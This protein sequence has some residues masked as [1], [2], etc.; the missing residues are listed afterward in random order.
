M[1][2][3]S[4]ALETQYKEVMKVENRYLRKAWQIILRNFIKN[5]GEYQ[6]YLWEDYGTIFPNGAVHAEVIERVTTG[7]DFEDEVERSWRAQGIDYKGTPVKVGYEDI[8]LL[9][10]SKEVISLAIALKGKIHVEKYQGRVHLNENEKWNVARVCQELNNALGKT[11]KDNNGLVRTFSQTSVTTKAMAKKLIAFAKKLTQEDPAATKAD[12]KVME[13]IEAEFLKEY[14]ETASIIG[15]FNFYEGI[16]KRHHALWNPGDRLRNFKGSRWLC[17]QRTDG[18]HS[19]SSDY[20]IS[21]SP[22]EIRYEREN[23]KSQYG[24]FMQSRY[25]SDQSGDTQTYQYTGMVTDVVST[26][27]LVFELWRDQKDRSPES[28]SYIVLTLTSEA[29]P[30]V[31]IGF[32]MYYSVYSSRYVTKSVLFQHF[33]DSDI[34]FDL[35]PE[36]RK[37]PAEQLFPKL[38][39]DY[40]PDDDPKEFKEIPLLIRRFLARRDLNRLT[41]PSTRISSLEEGENSLAKWMDSR[42]G[43][44]AHPILDACQGNYSIYYFYGDQ[45][46]EKADTDEIFQKV[47]KD[48][49]TISYDENLA[50][51]KALFYHERTRN[52]TYTGKVGLNMQ[53]IEINVEDNGDDKYNST[54]LNMV[55]IS[56][57]IPAHDKGVFADEFKGKKSLEGLIAGC[58]DNENTPIALIAMIIKEVDEDLQADLHSTKT[59]S[60]ERKDEVA[61]FL[62]LNRGQLSIKLKSYE[63]RTASRFDHLV[64][65]YEDKGYD[66]R[67]DGNK[68][69]IYELESGKTVDQSE[70]DVSP[71]A[72]VLSRD[73]FIRQLPDLNEK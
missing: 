32:H 60:K 17:F 35:N 61:D 19:S 16:V 50:A 70:P 18:C 30:D 44:D 52:A 36:E 67:R 43:I 7:V 53:T 72:Y 58:N 12:E 27:S 71:F 59:D 47:R 31:L 49:L 54:E 33:D 65:L 48:R 45:I 42:N 21:I 66:S 2:S 1:R 37:L 38:S 3:D 68:R 56:F 25:H 14:P 34:K 55:F 28:V 46:A 51:F 9:K 57:T 24:V 15:D 69:I 11:T 29:N 4:L 73:L 10:N 63:N 64:K 6:Q 22:L 8:L 39:H 26:N 20:G 40:N 62:R 41:Q 5:P 13:A 23:N